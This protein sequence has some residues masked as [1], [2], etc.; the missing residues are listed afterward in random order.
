MGCLLKFEDA[1][2]SFVSSMFEV[3]DIKIDLNCNDGVFYFMNDDELAGPFC[4]SDRSRRDIEP[5]S[6]VSIYLWITSYDTVIDTL[7]IGNVSQN[8]C[9]M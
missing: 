8:Y 2:E 1:Y 6:N 4:T 9:D 7:L 3:S 5:N